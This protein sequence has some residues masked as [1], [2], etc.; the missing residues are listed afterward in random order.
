LFQPSAWKFLPLS[1]E[2]A[3]PSQ[4]SSQ[5]GWPAES[6]TSMFWMVA[7]SP[8]SPSMRHVFA[9]ASRPHTSL[10]LKVHTEFFHG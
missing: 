3:A 9:L 10:K 7:E 8:M 4:L 5:F 6:Q 1:F 2:V